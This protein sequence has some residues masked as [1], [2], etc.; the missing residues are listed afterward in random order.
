M[1]RNIDDMTERLDASVRKIVDASAEVEGMERALR[2]LQENVSNTASYGGATQST[3]EQ[4]K[5]D[6]DIGAKV[7][8][9]MMRRANLG[10]KP[11]KPWGE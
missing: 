1:R 2:E 7:W 5:P 11:R 3:L 10:T 6:R 8:V 9:L 4:V